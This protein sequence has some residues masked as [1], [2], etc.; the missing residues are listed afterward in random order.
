MADEVQRGQQP[1]LGVE[2]RILPE[3]QPELGFQD[4]I[5]TLSEKGQAT[6][7]A[8]IERLKA[9]NE[10]LR[11][12]GRLDPKL[13]EHGMLNDRGFRE[14]I[15]KAAELVRKGKLKQVVFLVGDVNKFKVINDTLGHAKGDEVLHKIAGALKEYD[16]VAR[17][18]GDEFDILLQVFNDREGFVDE[19][20]VKRSLGR[21]R[22]LEGEIPGTMCFGAKIFTAGEFLEV[23]EEGGDVIGKLQKDA[24]KKMY[25]AKRAGK[26]GK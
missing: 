9:E 13:G 5:N 3:Q 15:Q 24:D 11:R 6:V 23:V 7:N 17:L 1:E 18:G 4:H 12:Q 8:E 2:N 10:R 14:E 20:D 19:D 25:D 21:V 26:N 22:E 16:I